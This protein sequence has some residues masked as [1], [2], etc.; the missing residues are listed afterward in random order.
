MSNEAKECLSNHRDVQ[1]RNEIHEN[2]SLNDNHSINEIPADEC[3][4]I[5]AESEPNTPSETN[6]KTTEIIPS[7]SSVAARKEP[8]GQDDDGTKWTNE[9]L[10]S[11]MYPEISV[12]NTGTSLASLTTQN[13]SADSCPISS[14]KS[15]QHANALSNNNTKLGNSK[16]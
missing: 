12:M 4:L 8:M 13:S 6:L 10:I 16:Y 11:S 9:F 15:M 2:T 7:N 3:C 14:S 1:T 5:E